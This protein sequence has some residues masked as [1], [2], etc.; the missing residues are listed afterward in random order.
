MKLLLEAGINNITASADIN[1]LDCYGE[2]PLMRAVTWND[3]TMIE[4]LLEQGA[5]VNAKNK[6]GVTALMRPALGG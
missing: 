6:D 4:L 1:A 2:T 5:D 3:S